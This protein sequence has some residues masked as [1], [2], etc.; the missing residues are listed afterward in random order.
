MVSHY[1]HCVGV[2]IVI[3]RLAINSPIPETIA[4]QSTIPEFP[5]ANSDVQLQK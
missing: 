2:L 3:T 5:S 1:R 4:I